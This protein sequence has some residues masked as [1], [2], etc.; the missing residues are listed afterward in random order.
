MAGS[1]LAAGS[2]HDDHANP[3]PDIRSLADT[4]L[5]RDLLN[6]TERF[7][8]PVIIREITIFRRDRDIWAQVRSQ[9]GAPGR[10]IGSARQA[11]LISI[12]ETL[13][14]PF[15]L[16]K[17]AR[18]IES[19][20]DEVYTGGSRYKFAGMPFFN[21]VALLEL[22]VFD[23][24]SRTADVPIHALLGRKLRDRIPVYLS[25][26]TRDNRP[27]NEAEALLAE[28]EKSGAK[29]VKI[30]LGARMSHNRDGYPG[31]FGGD[32]STPAQGPA[33]RHDPPC[34]C[35]RLVRCETC[36]RDRQADGGTRLWF[37]RG[38]LSVAG[39]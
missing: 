13:V 9:D 36:R 15:F 3:S 4:T 33:R 32:H 27:E 7:K 20:V 25:R 17:D 31:A 1:L 29:A 30:K 6:L 26:F 12:L 14:I 35:Q 8:Q 22:A 34:R 23:M 21:C 39:L 19:L 11:S 28:L 5:T 24:L 16:G 37:L 38:T 2:G 18:R 10:S